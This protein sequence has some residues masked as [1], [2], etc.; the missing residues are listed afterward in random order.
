[1]EY[2]LHTCRSVHLTYSWTLS[3]TV[4]S[5]RLRFQRRAMRRA[6]RSVARQRFTVATLQVRSSSLS[7]LRASAQTVNLC[8][9]SPNLPV[10]AAGDFNFDI[11]QSCPASAVADAHF[12]NPFAGVRIQ[13]TRP[14]R[15]GRSKAVDW[16]LARG[17][18]RATAPQVHSSIDASDHYPLSLEVHLPR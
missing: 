8:T 13:T 7:Q 14:P 4:H 9:N 6:L 5:G 10:I 18:V 15:F 12:Y 3:N 2:Q 17:T 11:T 1:M 16:I